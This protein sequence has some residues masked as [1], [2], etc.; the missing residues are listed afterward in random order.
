MTVFT[1]NG[2][3]QLLLLLCTALVWAQP[4]GEKGNV[5]LK[6]DAAQ[7]VGI[8]YA[9]IVG[10]SKY[11]ASDSYKNLEYADADAKI[12]YQYL[13]SPGGG[14][15]A[16]ENVVLL[17][18]EK[19]TNAGFW[20]AFAPIKEKLKKGDVFYVYF[21]GHGDAYQ[22][23]EAYLLAYDAPPGKDKNNY[24]TGNGLI[25]IYKLKNRFLEIYEKGAQVIFITDACRTNELPGS[26]KGRQNAMEKIME[27]RAMEVQ[28]ISC[29]SNQV[30]YEDARWGGGRGLFSWHL[31]NGLQGLAD[32]EPQD[33][34]VTLTELYDYV[35]RNVNKASYDSINQ[36]Y[37]QTPQYCCSEYDSYVIA[38]VDEGEKQK[39]IAQ[40]QAGVFYSPDKGDF[41][42]SKSTELEYAMKNAGMD[43][44]YS[45]FLKALNQDSIFGSNGAFSIYQK[46]LAQKGTTATLAADLKYTLQASLMNH[47]SKVINTYLHA[48]TNNNNYNF[49]FFNNA[50]QCLRLFQ[51]IADTAYYN[52]IDVQVNL[53]F[54]ES[55]SQWLSYKTPEILHSLAQIDSA[56]ALKPQA[57]YLYNLKGL[58]HLKLNQFG[59]ARASLTKGIALAPNWIYP[60]HN[61]GSM[62]TYQSKWDSAMIFYN[63]ALAIDSTYQTTY[64]GVAGMYITQKKTDSAIQWTLKGLQQDSTDGKLWTQ[65]GIEYMQLKDWP[66]ATTAFDKGLYYDSTFLPALEGALK[67]R[68]YD[69]KNEDSVKYYT[70]KL[71]LSNP[72]NPATYLALGELFTEMQMYPNAIE[73]LSYSIALDSINPYTW[74]V[75]H[76]VYK[77]E[78][79][80]TAAF[81]VLAHAWVLD[82]L[83]VGTNNDLGNYYFGQG[84]YAAAKYFFKVAL[85]SDAE[86]AVLYSNYAMAAQYNNDLAE[87]EE[88]YLRSIQKDKNN[89]PAYFQLAILLAATKPADAIAYLEKALA[90]GYTTGHVLDEPA[91]QVLK[92]NKQFKALLKKWGATPK[93]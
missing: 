34:R 26:E 91:L 76:K 80:D 85:Q 25:D 28:L 19:A 27:R 17:C 81:N 18:N 23:N 30:S 71:I 35:K 84:N 92:D 50:A 49:S 36:K 48:G 42:A 47:V 40:L 74:R 38:R 2:L 33:G 90:N 1:K 31:I 55:H 15:L 9:L 13:V 22:A 64:G 79:M 43:D 82:S 75:L 11:G 68:I 93:N 7:P 10:V 21:S 51:Q 32:T 73:Q 77:A 24:S 56:I 5:V 83:D 53:L 63:K 8:S 87:A 37:K 29:A 69:F 58:L 14:R 3:L 52:P 78:G 16:K 57:A 41:T 59:K 66:K 20:N 39:L 70:T 60:Y 72:Q 65:L 54:L 61:M 88:Y 89:G 46:I 44:L 12:F 62:F 4:P 45:A 6:K 67:V 86:N